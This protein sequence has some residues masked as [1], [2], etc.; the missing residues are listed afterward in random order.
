[1][2][3]QGGSVAPERPLC[4][5]SAARIA[6]AEMSAADSPVPNCPVPKRPVPKYPR[7]SNEGDRVILRGVEPKLRLIVRGIADTFDEHSVRLFP[8]LVESV[9]ALPS[10]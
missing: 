1:M 2:Q 3:I 4:E 8:C 5:I 7:P 6:G 10:R 9:N